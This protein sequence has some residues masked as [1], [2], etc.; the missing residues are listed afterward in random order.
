MRFKDAILEFGF[1][2]RARKLS[3]KTISNYQ[4]Q[5]R[6]LE[7]YLG[8][9]YGITEVEDVRSLHLKE[10]LV[11]MDEKGR[12]PRYIND[13]LKVFKTFFNYLKREA[14]IRESP[15][16]KVHNMKQPKVKIITFSEEEIRKL[17]NYYQGRSFLNI[18]N[19]TMIA[20]F[21]DT[22]M[23]LTEVIT[24]Q[25]EQIREDSIIV[26]GK[27]NKERL[28]PVSPYLAK[29]LMQYQMVREA[30]FDGKLPERYLFVSSIAI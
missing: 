23:R 24:L 17:L 20:L 13:L 7:R 12:K 10:F 15:A 3:D 19:R 27:G 25:A 6:Y 8:A 4:K 30:Y 26:H 14:Y 11:S 9:E 22:G 5:L 1:D 2:C 18:R 21:F 16:A 28:V 29:A